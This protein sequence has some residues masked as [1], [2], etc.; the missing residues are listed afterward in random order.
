[1]ESWYKASVTVHTYGSLR[2]TVFKNISQ[3]FKTCV[4]CQSIEGNNLIHNARPRGRS[5]K[6]FEKDC[7]K[8]LPGT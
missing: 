2:I 6:N 1:V 5:K 7:G 3:Q 4:K 8:R